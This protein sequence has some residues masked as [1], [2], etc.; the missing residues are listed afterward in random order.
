MSG[1]DYKIAGLHIKKLHGHY[2]GIDGGSF[3]VVH[4]VFTG[5]VLSLWEGCE[6][7]IGIGNILQSS[8]ETTNTMGN[9]L[10][11]FMEHDHRV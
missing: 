6:M 1:Y 11:V 4:T 10:Q 5:K 9:V 2:F 8:R 3:W 7:E